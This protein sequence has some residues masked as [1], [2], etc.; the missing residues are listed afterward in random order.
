M[1]LIIGVR[2][3]DG[4]VIGA[5][6]ISTYGTAIEQEVSD[7]IQFI[8]RDAVVG[9]AGAVGLSQLINDELRKRWDRVKQQSD[10]TAVKNEISMTIWSQ[11]SPALKRAE[12]ARI[13]LGNSVI[14]NTLCHSLVALPVNNSPTLLAF[15]ECAQPLEITLDSTFFSIGSGSLQADPFLAFVKRILWQGSVPRNMAEGIFGVLWTLDHVSRVNAGLGVG[16][17]P[18]VVV[19]QKQEDEW[20]AEK[21]SDEALDEHL[22]GIRIAENYMGGFRNYF[23]PGLYRIDK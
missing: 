21:L 12:E 7:K 10:V 1:T 19:L 16:G 20:R 4:L 2:W 14:E 13:G 8:A 3:L 18:N 23:S 22:M 11:V 5:D 6:S 17:R 15:D 9:N